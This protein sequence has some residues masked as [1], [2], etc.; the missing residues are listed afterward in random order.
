MVDSD[1]SL[2]PIVLPAKPLNQHFWTIVVGSCLLILVGFLAATYAWK[3]DHRSALDFFWGPI[4][5]GNEAVLICIADQL[6]YG[7]VALRDSADPTRQIL[8]KDNL[9]A[10]VIDD[11]NAVIQSAGIL[12]SNGRQKNLKGQWITNLTDLRHGPNV[13]VGAFDN[14]WTLRLTNPLRYH[15]AN[16]P[17]M[18][19]FRI[20]DSQSPGQSSWGIDRGKQMATNNYRDYAIVARFTDSNT[21]KLAVIIAGVGRGGRDGGGGLVTH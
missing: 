21:G 6:Q 9:T 11:L 5:N 19:Q 14:A 17:N 7:A 12:N 2:K 20:V 3:A 13:F 15:F 10:V 16:D 8:L 18:T 4:F 1:R